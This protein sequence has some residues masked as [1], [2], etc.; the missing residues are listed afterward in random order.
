MGGLPFSDTQSTWLPE[1]GWGRA[2]QA[3]WTPL[4]IAFGRMKMRLL[5]GGR[6]TEW[7]KHTG[8]LMFTIAHC[9]FWSKIARYCK[10]EGIFLLTVSHMTFSQIN[11]TELCSFLQLH[12][13]FFLCLSSLRFA[14][15]ACNFTVLAQALFSGTAG[16]ENL[17][18]MRPAEHQMPDRQS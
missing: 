12:G 11:V 14:L 4:E 17:H 2:R 6:F 13:G 9:L 16:S 7:C 1:S 3:T 5:N 8:H 18:C 15:T 10:L